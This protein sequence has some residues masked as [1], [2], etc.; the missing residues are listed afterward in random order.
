[1]NA[2]SK[3]R[4]H[5]RR[6]KALARRKKHRKG[7]AAARSRTLPPATLHMVDGR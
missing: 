5:E 4:E 3:A 1:M 2:A 7:R 6:M